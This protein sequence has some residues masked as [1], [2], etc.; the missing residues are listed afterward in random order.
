MSDAILVTQQLTHTYTLASGSVTPFEQLSF[1]IRPN[2]VVAVRGPS[3]CGKTTL[4]LACGGMRVP[5]RGEVTLAGRNLYQMSTS[6]R[7][8]YR[9]Q[10]IGFLFQTLELLPYLSVAQNVT[11]AMAG[12]DHDFAARSMRWI[13]DLGLSERINHRPQALSQGE[14]QRVALARSLAHQPAILVCD[15]PTGNLDEDNAQMVFSALRQFADEGGAVLVASHDHHVHS[16]AD[17]TLSLPAANQNAIVRSGGAADRSGSVSRLLAFA[18][19]SACLVLALVVAALN[20]RPDAARH[21]NPTDKVRIYCA[22]GVAKPV[23]EVIQVYNA[24]FSANIEIVRTGGSGELA[25]QLATEFE[26]DMNSGADLYLSADRLLLNRAFDQSMI[27]ERFSIA[28]QQLVIAVPAQSRLKF[29][30]IAE[31][32]HHKQAKFGLASER[33]AV[34]KLARKIANRQGVLTQLEERKTTDAENV[35]TLAQALAAGSLDAALIWDTTVNQ[36]NRAG[37]KNILKIAAVLGHR[38]DKSNIGIGLVSTTRAPTAALKFCRFLTGSKTSQTA[39]ERFGFRFVAGDAWEEVPQVHLYCGSMF[40]PVLENAIQEFA[41]REGVNVYPRWQGCGKLVATM[42]S[43]EDPEL[44]PDAFLA[45]DV[46][47]LDQVKDQFEPFRMVSSN[48]IVIAVRRSCL[49]ELH[50]PEALLKGE[51]RF[52]ICDPQQ[53]ALGALTQS[54]LSQQPYSDLYPR[55]Y[56]Q[57]NVISDVGPT[58]ISQLLAEG[59]DAA[60]VYRSNVMADPRA[61]SQLKLIEFDSNIAQARQPWAVSK[62]TRNPQLMKRLFEWISRKSIQRKFAEFG[63]ENLE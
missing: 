32:V 24:R 60:I 19:F 17:Q 46:S 59:L 25:G 5:T 57:A 63:F 12:F 10:N 62:C 3:G 48:D 47:F 50:G 40:T 54:L 51:V 33:A 2:Q 37:D 35:M 21:Q 11:V 13:S 30:S 53:S 52:G 38:D 8:R 61:R 39:F 56:D 34:G 23:E 28:E 44:F 55:I 58:L 9:A 31:L 29:R 7:A 15:E 4:L 1:E 49:D 14:R 22:A 43:N 6:E 36:L 16:I 45:C 41:N 26:T 20:L 27:D 42:K 18:M